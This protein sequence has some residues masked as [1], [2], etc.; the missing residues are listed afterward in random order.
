VFVSNNNHRVWVTP[1]RRGKDNWKVAADQNGKTPAQ[2]HVAMKWAQGLKRV[3]NIDDETCRVCSGSAKELN[4]VP[5]LLGLLQKGVY[6]S[7]MQK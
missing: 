4:C 2:R 7:Y 5:I 1:A 3:F 6:L